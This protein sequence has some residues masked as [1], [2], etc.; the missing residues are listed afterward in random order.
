MEPKRKSAP[1]PRKTPKASSSWGK[2]ATWYDDLLEKDSDTYQTQVILPNLMRVL[3]VKRGE[4]VLDIACGQGFF[5]R[6]LSEAGAA[7]TGADISKELVALASK[8]SRCIP[9]HVAPSHE[10][11]FAKDG[12]YDTALIVLAIQNIEKMTETFAEAS[13]VLT[14]SGRLV[15]V[16]NHPAFR[17]LKHSS[18]GYDE[19]ARVQYRRVDRYLS[20]EKVLVDMHPGQR[21]SEHTVSYH[22][23]LQDI[24][25]ALRKSGFAI[26][27]MEEWISH[28][29]SGKGPRQNAENVARKEIPLFMMLEVQKLSAPRA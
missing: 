2:V 26:T 22:R 19:A 18:W 17:V 23:S 5:T 11:S 16:L 27:R 21:N 10:L 1:V 20:G 28:R 25:K 3:A 14:P 9:Y 15:L 4:R 13:R 6:A 8:T 24:S 12:S 29:I 7:A